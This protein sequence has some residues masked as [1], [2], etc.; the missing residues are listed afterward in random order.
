M[1][2]KLSKKRKKLIAIY[3]LLVLVL[4]LVIYILPKIT[5]IFE[6][7][8]TLEP[9]VLEISCE[10]EGYVVKDE[11]V[12]LADRTGDMVYLNR[13]GTVVKKGSE[14]CDIKKA[15]N[16][17]GDG[18]PEKDAKYSEYLSKLKN[19]KGLYSEE[20]SPISGIFS[21]TIDGGE[22]YFSIDNLDN[23]SK[24]KAEAFDFREMDLNREQ[25]V[26][27][28]PVYKI[29]GDDHWYAVCWIDSEDAGEYEEGDYVTLTLPAG[30]VKAK[31][32]EKKPEKSDDG[33]T[34][35]VV[36]YMNTYYKDLSSVRKEDMTVTMSNSSGLI[37]DNE[38]LIK[39][40]GQLGVYVKTKDDVYVFKPVNIKASTSKQSA[41]SDGTYVNENYEQV[42]T[43]NV[44]DE[45]LR[46]PQPA[47]EEDLAEEKDNK[48]KEDK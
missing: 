4:Y 7:T 6:T 24:E 26:E 31:L 45:V 25:V 23:I 38:C 20:D 33:K 13:D 43:V 19:Y 3:L 29:T 46:N 8:Q 5:D 35:R 32:T 1:Q 22:K 34:Q 30:D 9:G 37:V 15:E 42:V 18:K 47:L 48:D 27:G 44:Y 36:F 28:E 39:K 17:T 40:D 16:T 10:T 41:I 11:A 12:V 21:T 2:I 14:I